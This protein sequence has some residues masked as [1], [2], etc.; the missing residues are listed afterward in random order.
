MKKFLTVSVVVFLMIFT[1]GLATA[2][3]PVPIF[4]FTATGDLFSV[5]SAGTTGGPLSA[6]ITVNEAGG[7]F[8]GT[9]VIASSG[10][11]IDF[12]A[13]LDSE[14]VYTLNGQT[15]VVDAA[16]AGLVGITVSETVTGAF[17]ISKHKNPALTKHAKEVLA[18][19][20][21]LRTLDP[22]ATS[23]AGLLYTEA[24]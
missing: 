20:I 13:V 14:G 16:R 7:L 22:L 17:T 2:K 21:E 11:T 15:V 10:I 1:A 24:E 6:T 19:A 12:S 18:A 3:A 9:I 23:Y 5:T 4:P 8:Y